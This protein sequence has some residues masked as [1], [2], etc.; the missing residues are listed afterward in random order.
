M[1]DIKELFFNLYSKSVY[2]TSVATWFEMSICFSKDDRGYW[3]TPSPWDDLPD[4]WTPSVSPIHY[5]VEDIVNQFNHWQ[6]WKEVFYGEG[7]RRILTT[8][9]TKRRRR[10][11]SDAD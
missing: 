4:L 5:V 8:L 2:T 6:A 10:R 9:S 1:T 11:K 3:K 7:T